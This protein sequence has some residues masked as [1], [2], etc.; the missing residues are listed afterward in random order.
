M[1][2]DAIPILCRMYNDEIINVH[3]QASNNPVGVSFGRGRPLPLFKGSASKVML[4]LLPSAKLQKLYEKN[5]HLPDVREIATEW[6]DFKQHFTAI[7]KA[8]FYISMHEID[9]GVIGIAVP[10]YTSGIGIVGA[11]SLVMTEE[12]LQM[13]N[14]D[15]VVA[16]LKQRAAEFGD[17]LVQLDR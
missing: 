2:P 17:R 13:I 6:P 12:R 4:A 16:V 11:I 15:G 5:R 3:H 7:R 10:V 14:P 9:S 8:G 1:K